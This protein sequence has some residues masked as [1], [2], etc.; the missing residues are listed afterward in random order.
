MDGKKF[1]QRWQF[2][3]IAVLVIFILRSCVV[4]SRFEAEMAAAQASVAAT[5]AATL[6]LIESKALMLEKFKVFYAE[7]IDLYDR[8]DKMNNIISEAENLFT[9]GGASRLEMYQ[10]LDVGENTLKNIS[11]AIMAKDIPTG[12]TKG[13]QALLREAI[14]EFGTMAAVTEDAYE[15]YKEY[16]DKYSLEAASNYKSKMEA[17]ER[18]RVKGNLAITQVGVEVGMEY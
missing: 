17:A 6:S 2:Y 16:I 13:Q 14:L 18:H 10:L 9:A 8:V 3:V 5:P 1:Y 4:F 12:F 7:I 11:Y 15:Y